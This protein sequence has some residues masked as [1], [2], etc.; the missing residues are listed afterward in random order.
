MTQSYEERQELYARIDEN[1]AV[2]FKRVLLQLPCMEWA[3][4][5]LKLLPDELNK[6]SSSLDSIDYPERCSQT[7]DNPK[8]RTFALLDKWLNHHNNEDLSNAVT[9]HAL[10]LYGEQRQESEFVYLTEENYCRALS[11]I[12]EGYATNRFK[13]KPLIYKIASLVSIIRSDYVFRG[14]TAEPVSKNSS[15]SMRSV[16]I[17]NAMAALSAVSVDTPKLIEGRHFYN[18][19]KQR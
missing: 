7:A 17:L 13:T 2:D 16:A 9:L 11:A 8:H 1:K 19:R 18:R 3:K 15:P 5:K 6:M 4:G 12:P 14:D 10:K